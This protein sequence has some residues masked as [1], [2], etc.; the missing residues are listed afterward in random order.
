M[1]S[2]LRRLEFSADG[3][4]PIKEV[5]DWQRT[6]SNLITTQSGLVRLV[7]IAAYF[8][9]V[10]SCAFH[11]AFHPNNFLNSLLCTA[12]VEKTLPE[13]VFVEARQSLVGFI[14]PDQP[15]WPRAVALLRPLAKH[16]YLR[17]SVLTTE[18]V[19]GFLQLL[20]HIISVQGEHFAHVMDALS[21]LVEFRMHTDHCIF[22]QALIIYQTRI[23]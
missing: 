5:P 21:S 9:V 18:V 3:R 19:D 7:A 16:E 8:E 12:D 4:S 23:Q 2:F 13:E 11:D 10:D 1:G 15:D 20:D 6:L 17:Q 14:K 22:V